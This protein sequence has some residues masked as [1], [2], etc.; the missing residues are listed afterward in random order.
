VIQPYAENLI[1]CDQN[2]EVQANSME[3]LANVSRFICEEDIIYF[4]LQAREFKRSFS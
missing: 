2:G 3:M 4:D 1:D